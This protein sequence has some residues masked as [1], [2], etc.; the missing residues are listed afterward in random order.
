MST[1][2]F[3][4]IV[5]TDRY[6]AQVGILHINIQSNIL[7]QWIEVAKHDNPRDVGSTDDCG[8][9]IEE[10]QFIVVIFAGLP[11]EFMYEMDHQNR[12]LRVI[13]CHSLDIFHSF[14]VTY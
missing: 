8:N 14:E 4:Q 10:C 2:N 11:F 6:L 9:T 13:D 3:W 1:N 7:D 12:I 5:A